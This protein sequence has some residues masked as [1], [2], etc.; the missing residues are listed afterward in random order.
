MSWEK[1]VS[2]GEINLLQINCKRKVWWEIRTKLETSSPHPS[3][4][5]M[6]NS[7]LTLPSPKSY[8]RMGK[9]YLQSV[10]N[11]SSL[12]FLSP[13]AFSLFWYRVPPMGYSLS[14]TSPRVLVT[15]SARKPAPL[16]ASLHGSQIL[17]GACSCVDTLQA[18]AS[19]RAYL[20]APTWGAPRVAGW[21]WYLLHYGPQ[22]LQGHSCFT[23][24][25][26][27][28]CKGSLEFNTWSTSSPSLSTDLVSAE[29]LLSCFQPF[30]T[31]AAPYF[32]FLN[33]LSQRCYWCH[34]L[35]QLWPVVVHLIAGWHW[36]CLRCGQFLVSTNRSCLTASLTSKNLVT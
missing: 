14:L 17:L 20:P 35:V 29:L 16:C 13:H 4:L 27:P 30:L 33:I 9:L 25:C 28:A 32:L 21:Y 31:A 5:P 6:L 23:I 18:A 34:W 8:R 22:W 2:L 26:T 11:S 7:V 1:H 19:F 24:V 12:P 3:L 36:L 15:G 10:Q